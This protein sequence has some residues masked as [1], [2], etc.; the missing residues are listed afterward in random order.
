MFQI[1]EEKSSD[2]ADRTSELRKSAHYYN[3]LSPRNGP[4]NWNLASENSP[5]SVLLLFT[6]I[7]MVFCLFYANNN[8]L[9]LS[10]K[11]PYDPLIRIY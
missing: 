8:I 9:F 2:I 6:S 11:L 10:S 5:L 7:E 3:H 1:D 4:L